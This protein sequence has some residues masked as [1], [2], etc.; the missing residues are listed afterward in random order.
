[1]L[2]W[3]S[4]RLSSLSLLQLQ[5]RGISPFSLVIRTQALE[6][7][8]VDV[9][10]GVLMVTILVVVVVMNVSLKISTVFIVFGV[11]LLIIMFRIAQTR[12]GC[13]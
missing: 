2:R 1:M 12:F 6:D 9:V 11:V 10:E 4:Y 7:V 3:L 5:V 8:D 13:K